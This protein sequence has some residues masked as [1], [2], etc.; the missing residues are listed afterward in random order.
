M[1]IT[2]IN[3]IG[4]TVKLLEESTGK[5]LRQWYYSD[6]FFLAI[7]LK[8]W[9]MKPS[10]TNAMASNLKASVFKRKGNSQQS[11]E[12]VTV[13]EGEKILDNCS[14]EKGLISRLSK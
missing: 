5:H 4:K 13:T 14:S 8:R 3:H 9:E 6:F 7:I 11:G 1:T 12:T 2:L 10:L